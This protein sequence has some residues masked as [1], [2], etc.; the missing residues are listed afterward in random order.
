MATLVALTHRGAIKPHHAEL[1]PDE[2]PARCVYFTP[3]FERWLDDTL[4]YER[5]RRGAQETPSEQADQVLYDFIVG[6]RMSY[7]QTIRSLNPQAQGV[8]ELKTSDVRI[9]GYFARRSTFVA[10]VGAMKARLVPREGKTTNQLYR[11]F[12]D[13]AYRFASSLDLDPPP[14]LKGSTLADVL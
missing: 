14:Y 3:D 4:P 2:Q 10:V 11:P 6:R 8:W 5:G 13:E 1:E 12:R 7:P 9:F